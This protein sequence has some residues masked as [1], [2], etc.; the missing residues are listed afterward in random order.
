MLCLDGINKEELLNVIDYVYHG[1]I[2]I[3]QD[4][5]DR[6]LKIAQKLQLHGLLE[7]DEAPIQTK[8]EDCNAVDENDCDS[9][10]KFGLISQGDTNLVTQKNNST[11]IVLSDEIHSIDELDAK[12]EQN[13]TFV[14]SGMRCCKLCPYQSKNLSHTKEHVEIHFQ[15][16]FP[17]QKCNK[18]F[19]TR[20]TVRSHNNKIHKKSQTN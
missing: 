19:K 8:Y 13:I 12:I 9:K 7:Q 17:C 1:E 14:N 6:F 18:I 2:Q 3:F 4:N 16:Q 5:L 20:T 11:P 10:K 15:L